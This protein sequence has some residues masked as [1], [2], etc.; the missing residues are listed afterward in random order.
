MNL[1]VVN[2][3]Q[4]HPTVPRLLLST[5]IMIISLSL[6]AQFIHQQFLHASQQRILQMAQLGIYT[7]LPKSIPKLSH[8]FR[9]CIISKTPRLPCHPNVYT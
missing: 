7:G 3:Y 2:K 9:I 8:T 1:Q 6:N 5:I 4:S